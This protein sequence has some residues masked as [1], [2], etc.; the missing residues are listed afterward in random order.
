MAGV[1]AQ[2]VQPA[3]T[4]KGITDYSP[5]DTFRSSGPAVSYSATNQ[6]PF[7]DNMRDEIG[8]RSFGGAPPGFDDVDNDEI[9]ESGITGNLYGPFNDY[10]M[11][12]GNRGLRGSPSSSMEA[13]SVS[14][15]DNEP[16]R[17]E[18]GENENDAD[19]EPELVDA[20]DGI[21]EQFIEVKNREDEDEELYGAPVTT[22]QQSRPP[23]TPNRPVPP[24]PAS[25]ATTRESSAASPEGGREGA[26]S[27]SPE[28]TA[29]P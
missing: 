8:G 14:S 9:L 13:R 22:T 16:G 18:W 21:M 20:D 19:G 25:A 12:M 1:Q 6:N 23:T 17:M 28:P 27:P 11:G 10:V 7:E 15:L 24:P 4:P 2:P 3:A 26:P 29:V 5:P